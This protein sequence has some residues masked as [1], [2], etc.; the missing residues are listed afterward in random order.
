MKRWTLLALLA[1]AAC[2]STEYT[3]GT[4]AEGDEPEVVNAE[5]ELPA[6]FL[7]PRVSARVAML[8]APSDVDTLF[9]GDTVDV[10]RATAPSSV[11]EYKGKGK[12]V[13][14][15]PGVA[16]LAYRSGS[17]GVVFHRDNHQLVV[18]P[19]PVALDTLPADTVIAPVPV[20]PAPSPTSP[21]PPILVVPPALF[22]KVAPNMLAGLTTYTSRDFRSK[23]SSATDV[24]GAQGWDAWLE[25]R[26]PNLTLLSDPSSG[27]SPGGFVRYT[28]PAGLVSGNGPASMQYKILDKAAREIYVAVWLRYGTNWLHSTKLW[29]INWSGGSY[30]V[31]GDAQNPDPAGRV[32]VNGR[33]NH[34]SFLPGFGNVGTSGELVR[35]QWHLIEY[36]MKLSSAPLAKDG[37]LRIWVDGKLVA[38]RSQWP[39]PGQPPYS[40]IKFSTIYGG[41][42][43]APVPQVMHIDFDHAVI[44]G[45]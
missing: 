36:Y 12:Y 37:E 20:T 28:F 10:T 11:M 5:S 16:N 38:S 8:A 23:A 27:G 40:E 21:P 42:L 1:L 29:Y 39:W 30:L 32:F 4:P 7:R 43:G 25:S 17:A 33:T 15:A 9:V 14:I 26:Y 6:E 34:S 35:G 2:E 31:R 24:T 19:R 41:M 13:L 3:G 45:K 18:L 44:A 22:A